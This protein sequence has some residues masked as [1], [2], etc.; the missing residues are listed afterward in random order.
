MRDEELTK[1]II[2]AAIEVHKHRGP[3]LLESVYEKSL[4]R[5]S[6]LPSVLLVFDRP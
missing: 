4:C 1:Q 3:I 6:Q 5:E 2:G